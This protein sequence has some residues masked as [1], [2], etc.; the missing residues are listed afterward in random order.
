MRT[1]AVAA[2]DLQRMQAWAGQAA[3]LGRDE[4]AHEAVQR[5]WNDV[6]ELL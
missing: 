6:K 4:P 3:R 2:D 1:A 5:I